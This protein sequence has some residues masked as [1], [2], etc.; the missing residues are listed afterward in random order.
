[1]ESKLVFSV[2]HNTDCNMLT[3]QCVDSDF[4]TLFW[5]M[6][7]KVLMGTNTVGHYIHC[8]D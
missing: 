4:C 7:S 3:W 6:R 2:C 5:V 1:M 8:G